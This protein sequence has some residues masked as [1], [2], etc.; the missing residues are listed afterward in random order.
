MLR[1]VNSKYYQNMILI[2]Y[3][4][5][6][7]NSNPIQKVLDWAGLLGRISHEYPYKLEITS[8]LILI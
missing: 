2:I 5:K 4:V 7:Y 6:F 3:Q 8:Q 1:W